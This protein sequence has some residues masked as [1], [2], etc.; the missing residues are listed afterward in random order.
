MPKL[1]QGISLLQE[2][3]RNKAAADIFKIINSEEE[4]EKALKKFKSSFEI[5]WRKRLI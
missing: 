1:D 3:V 5:L 2:K 4:K